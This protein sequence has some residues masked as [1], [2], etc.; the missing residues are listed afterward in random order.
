MFEAEVL[1]TW[2]TQL[3]A[4]ALTYNANADVYFTN[5]CAYWK[6]DNT[7]R[8]AQGLTPTAKPAHLPVCSVTTDDGGYPALVWAESTA[9][10]PDL[11][12][13]AVLPSGVSEIG[14][15]FSDNSGRRYAGPRDTV[16][17][18]AE[19]TKD[20]MVYVK[21]IIQTPFGP[22]KWYEPKR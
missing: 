20:G 4:M 19:A 1:A 10:C 17:N 2:R 16:A 3:E 8:A 14:E 5:A 12:A 15:L 18:G 13:A 22:S 11:P 21:V 9:V 7:W 6:E